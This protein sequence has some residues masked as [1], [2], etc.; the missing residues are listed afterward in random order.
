MLATSCFEW[1]AVIQSAPA[2]A[3][4]VLGFVFCSNDDRHF[5]V[6]ADEPRPDHDC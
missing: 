5:A 3:D 4:N 1:Q 2:H 6:G